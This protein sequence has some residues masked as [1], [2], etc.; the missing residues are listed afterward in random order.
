MRNNHGVTKVGIIK[1][2][3]LIIVG[4]TLL[5]IGFY[6][7]GDK[8]ALDDNKQESVREAMISSL[9]EGD[10]RLIESTQLLV[11]AG[12]YS[13]EAVETVNGL[14][15]PTENA[16]TI[17]CPQYILPVLPEL[18]ELPPKEVMDTVTRDQL[19]FILYQHIKAHQNRTVEVRKRIFHSYAKYLESCE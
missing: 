9:D 19:N 8:P 2:I 12:I 16:E 13:K 5:A 10:E 11:D 1:L 4:G 14:I 6:G 7:G 17:L 15:I 18:P 3:L